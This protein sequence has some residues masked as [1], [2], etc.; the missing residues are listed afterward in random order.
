MEEHRTILRCLTLEVATSSEEIKRSDFKLYG[1][2][3]ESP[4]KL[5]TIP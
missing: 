1:L 5:L 2:L 3:S 4:H